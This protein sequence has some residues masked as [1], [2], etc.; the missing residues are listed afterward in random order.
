MTIKSVATLIGELTVIAGVL[1]PVIVTMVR[2]VDGQRCQLRS[3]MLKIYYRYCDDEMIPQY[4]YENFAMLYKAYKALH[5]NSFIEK[6]WND[7]QKWEITR[8]DVE[9]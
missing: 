8:K 5:G 6:I 3:E 9:P 2:L 7:I 1:V 4:S